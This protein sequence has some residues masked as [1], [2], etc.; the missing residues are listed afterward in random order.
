MVFLGPPGVGKTHLAISLAV[1]VAVAAAERERRIY[2]GALADLLTALQNHPAT[3]RDVTLRLVGSGPVSLFPPPHVLTG[4]PSGGT[5][6]A[7]KN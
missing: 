1:A 5:F 2:Y 6:R 7:L 4:G 3:A